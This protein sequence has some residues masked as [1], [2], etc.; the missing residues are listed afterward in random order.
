MLAIRARMAEAL[1]AFLAFEG[2]LS[3]VE[4][5]VLSEVVFVLK[6]LAADVT[7]KGTLA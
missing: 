3:A 1:A 7:G 5:L 4:P 6:G 2:F